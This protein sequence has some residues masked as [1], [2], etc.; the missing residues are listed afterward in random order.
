M[1]KIVNVHKTRYV[2]RKSKMKK[3]GYQK[4]CSKC[5]RYM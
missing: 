3:G 4:R 1:G 2:L 5:G